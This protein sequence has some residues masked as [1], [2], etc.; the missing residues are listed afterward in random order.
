MADSIAATMH[1]A[2]QATSD[3]AIEWIV[4]DTGLWGGLSTLVERRRQLMNVV[5]G[6]FPV[7]HVAPKPC[8]W[9]G[10]HR[11][12]S[13]DYWAKANALN[14]G[15]VYA[16]YN[17]VACF[18]DC[19]IV[20]VDWLDCHWKAAKSGAAA[21][22]AYKYLKAGAKIRHGQVIEGEVVSDDHRLREKPNVDGCPPAWLYGGNFSVPLEAVLAVDGLDEIMDG[23]GGLEDCEFGARV[24]RVVSCHWY[25][26]AEIF[27]LAETHEP[28]LDYTGGAAADA[29]GE[30]AAPA[31]CKGFEF[32]DHAN[33]HHWMTWNHAPVWRLWGEKPVQGSDG[34]WRRS[35][36]P[37][38]SEDSHRIKSIGNTFSLQYLR[39]LLRAGL[40][41]P[42]PQ[43]PTHDWRDNV[44]LGSM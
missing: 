40:P 36:A 30:A 39:Y 33:T 27:Q 9:Q 8:V 15:F 13:K 23:S 42:I 44:P 10:P 29:R 6:R 20:S 32:I 38:F 25:P 2:R 37:E 26:Q 18:D 12:T 19:T 24:G 1:K 17:H 41:L 22:G 43:G 28:I 14:T 35:A 11:L 5:A 34:L 7:I 21:A 16:N 3:L 31:R 4:V